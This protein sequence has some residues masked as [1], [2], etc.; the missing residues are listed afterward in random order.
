M[1]VYP[2]LNGPS[3]PADGVVELE[4]RSLACYVAWDEP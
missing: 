1:D 3:P 2:G 4:G